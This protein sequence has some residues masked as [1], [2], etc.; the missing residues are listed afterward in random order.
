MEIQLIAT[1][2]T[3]DKYGRLIFT[4]YSHV[5]YEGKLVNNSSYD[6]INKLNIDR[7][8]VADNP[9]ATPQKICTIA[10]KLQSSYDFISD[11]VFSDNI[12]K[13]VRIT[14]T[15]RSYKVKSGE[16]SGKSGTSID[17]VAITEKL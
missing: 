1:P 3:K 2:T 13:P 17:L 6:T 16:R 12:G 11:G 4:I 10:C 14:V 9:A 15:P 8:Y 7:R 5:M